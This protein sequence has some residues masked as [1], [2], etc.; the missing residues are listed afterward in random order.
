MDEVKPFSEDLDNGSSA[1]K[2]CD[3]ESCA[4]ETSCVTPP[5]HNLLHGVDDRPAWYLS[6]MYAFQVSR[7]STSDIISTAVSTKKKKSSKELPKL[8]VQRILST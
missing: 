6:I 2:S 4:Q 3:S 5:R 8:A 1:N 7:S